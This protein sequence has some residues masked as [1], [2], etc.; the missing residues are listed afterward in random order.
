MAKTINRRLAEL[1]DSNGQLVS[2]KIANGYI[3]TAHYSAN[4]ITDTKLH[5]SFSLPASA[6]TAIDT[7]DVSE[8]STNIYF[9]NARADARIAAADT[10]DLS[11]GSNLYY[12]DARVG[13]YISGNRSYGNITTTGYIAGPATFTIDPAAVGDNTGTVVIAGNLQVDGTT[14]T[15]NSTTMTVDDLNLTL[16]SGAANAAAANGA[17]ITV[18]GASAT[19][20]YDGTNDE[21]D[22]NKHIRGQSFSVGAGPTS[23]LLFLSGAG[24]NGHGTTNARSI[25]SFNLTGQSAGL[26]FGAR[27]DETTGIIG[28]RTATG[29]LAFETYNSGW[30]ER[31]RITYDGNVGIGTAS[32]NNELEVKNSSPS[33]NTTIFLHNNSAS[34]AAVFKARGE[35]TGANSDVSQF[36]TDN[37][38]KTITNIRGVTD[39]TS[40]SGRLEF[41][42][43][44]S[45]SNAV[46]RMTIDDAGNVGIGN[47]SPATKFHVSAGS[48]NANII[49]RLE[50]GTTAGNYSAVEVGRTDGSGNVQITPAVTGGVP[51]SGIPGILLGSTNTALPAVAIQTPNSSSGHIVF[52]PKGTERMRIDSSGNMIYG[53]STGVQEKYFS[54][55]TAGSTSLYVDITH[56]ADNSRGTVLH[57]QAA[58]THHPSYDCILDTWVS[59]RSSTFSHAELLRRDTTLSGS[60]TVS[61]VSNT[62]TRITKNAGTYAG[63]GPYWIK[64]TWKN[65]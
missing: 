24:H 42:T 34:H 35:R 14:T 36:L 32:P 30:G 16:A 25:A 60:W 6:L 46:Q 23:E 57:I 52:N 37:S 59:R 45:S 2:G 50:Q 5:T 11:E 31:M 44:A 40:T 12:T 53:G 8:G 56:T 33:T 49:A 9:T 58:F 39:T 47:I 29:N 26:W 10:G 48:T 64:A 13:T 17:G 3:T 43:A 55:S 62:V 19:I 22:F 18:D 28:T 4:S 65:N 20:T 21:W 1:I 38:G 54:G 41:W 51:I 7:D 61:Y 15:I 27:N 63:T